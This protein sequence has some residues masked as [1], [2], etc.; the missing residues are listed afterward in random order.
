M[1]MTTPTGP[2]RAPHPAPIRPDNAQLALVPYSFSIPSSSRN[3]SQIM[4]PTLQGLLTLDLVT[5]SSCDNHATT[6]HGGRLISHPPHWWTWALRVPTLISCYSGLIYIIDAPFRCQDRWICI[7]S[8]S[9][10]G[11][12]IYAPLYF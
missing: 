7:L 9:W 6:H 3:P 1:I 11:G 10:I 4:I 8:H 12:W 5:W 2:H